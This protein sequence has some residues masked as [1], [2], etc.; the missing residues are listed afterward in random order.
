MRTRSKGLT[1]L[2]AVGAATVLALSACGGGGDSDKGTP[3]S[4]AGFADCEKNPNTCNGGQAKPGGEYIF[5]LEQS[6]TSWNINTEEGNTFDASKAMSG[7]I[8]QVY[9]ADPAGQMQLNA[10]LMV[11][12]ELTNQNPQT[13]VYKI[14]PDAVWND[15]TPISADDFTLAWKQNSGKKEHC[16]GC[17][18]ATTSGYDLIKSIVGSDGGKTV[19]LTFEDGKTYA[20]WKGLY[21]TDGLYPAH[22]ATKQGFD[23]S[24]PEGV[25]SAAD[26]FSETV[27]TWSGGPL[28]IDTFTKDQSLVLK[29]NDKWYGKVKPSL[30]KV[31]FKFIIDQG[32]VIPA[33][34]NKEIL[35]MSPQ[36]NAALVNGANETPGVI[37]RIGH[38]YTWE[39]LDLN[40]KNKYLADV[41]LRQ[42]IFTAI[43]VKSVIDK[44]YGVFDKQAKPLG[45]HNLFPG[46]P[47]YKDV[48]APT[49]QGSG[50]VEKAKKILTDA[51]YKIEN[52]KLITKSGEPV[53]ALRFR[54][55]KGNQLRATTGELVQAAL[56]NIGVEVKIEVTETLGKTLSTGDF[57][58][59]IFAWVGSPL[60]QGSAE[61]NWVTGNGGN[62]GG[63]SNADVDRLVKQGAQELDA[64]KAADLLNQANEIMAKDAY[65][66]PLVQKPTLT[67][68][69]SDYVNIR[70][71]ATQ[72]GPTYNI[73][74]WG[75]KA[76]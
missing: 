7:L 75:Q 16:S 58:I 48:V 39:H 51:G 24:K 27:P 41:A 60:F 56:K 11:S 12:A 29:K 35:G 4:N 5:G 54:H 59:M 45:S 57:D 38:G 70:D 55:T 26:W 42:A 44:T 25:N 62:Y 74:E 36:P 69:Y 68:T 22:L 8:P 28:L 40:L 34:R 53:P 50:D 52:G 67:F 2:V 46:D 17:T 9:K 33:L 32:S 1:S 73:Q 3:T 18:P 21:S 31:V 65:V 19:T 66:L 72:W 30:D 23:L 10:D 15:G 47:N 37:Y 71:N 14:K 43:N 76:A 49:G 61:Q 64:K 13:V 20:D 63:Y 6:F